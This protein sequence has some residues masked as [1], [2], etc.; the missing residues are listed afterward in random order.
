MQRIDIVG[1]KGNIM[2]LSNYA[3]TP[4]RPRDFY[5]AVAAVVVLLG[6]M[7]IYELQTGHVLHVSGIS[8]LLCVGV[9]LLVWGIAFS[10]LLKYGRRAFPWQRMVVLVGYTLFLGSYLWPNPPAVVSWV[11][12]AG[13]LVF[14]AIELSPF[15]TFKKKTDG[16]LS[17]SHPNSPS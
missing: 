14:M 6:G 7:G 11:G 16:A 5:I 13:F 4:V 17:G 9:L 12:N 10:R 3:R 15:L 1:G 2:R 8:P